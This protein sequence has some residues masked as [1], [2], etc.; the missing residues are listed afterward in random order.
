MLRSNHSHRSQT[1]RTRHENGTA[2]AGDLKRQ[3]TQREAKLIAR[4]ALVQKDL[5]VVRLRSL[6]NGA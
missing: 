3:M 6:T 5:L 1:I 4:R 2:L